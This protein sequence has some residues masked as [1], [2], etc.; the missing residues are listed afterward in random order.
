MKGEKNHNKYASHLSEHTKLLIKERNSLKEEAITTRSNDLWLQ[1]KKAR[2][3]LV[4]IQKKEKKKWAD[5]L[6]G[7]IPNDSKKIWAAAKTI[8]GD[9]KRKQIGEINEKGILLTDPKEVATALNNYFSDKI[10]TIKDEMPKPEI[11]M[12]EVLKAQSPPNIKQQE[13]LEINDTQLRNVVKKIKNTTATGVDTINSIV[14]KDIF[15]SIQ[16]TLLHLVNLSL[17]TGT[18]PEA[19]KM[20][21]ITP[22]VKPNKDAASVSSYR[23]VSNSCIFGKIIEQC[24]IE[25]IRE[26]INSHGLI[27]PNHHGGLKLHSTTTCLL[28]I[29]DAAKDALER[30]RKTALL[31]IDLSSAFDLVNHEMLLQ[32]CR[33]MAMSSNT[34]KWLKSFLS[35]RTHYV[36]VGG[37]KSPPIQMGE[38]GVIQGNISSGDLFV[39]FVNDMPISSIKGIKN[40]KQTEITS[41]MFVDDANSLISAT[42]DNELLVKLKCEFVRMQKYLINHKMKIND[43]KTQLMFLQPSEELRQRTMKI[44]NNVITH[45]KHMK[46]LGLNITDDLK[47]D[48][49]IWSGQQNMIKSLNAKTSILRTL[50]PF[51]SEKV[52]TMVGGNLINS[53]IQYCAPI[54]GTTTASNLA[55]IQGSQIKAARTIV[56]K[57]WNKKE[58][59]AHRQDTLDH[60]K[61]PNTT[62]IVK[63]ATINLTKRALTNNASKGI[64]NMFTSSQSLHTRMCKGLKIKHTGPLSRNETNFTAF[65]VSNF[66]N[67]PSN[68]RDPKMSTTKFK[69]K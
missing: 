68:L 22:I 16:R 63:A 5:K 2:N 7:N 52:L 15:P 59:K 25:Q 46:I 55:K 45:Q 28:E 29:V 47:F 66:N 34:L 20:T 36:E 38:E 57:K 42:S 27:N 44:G 39:I 67:L 64:N 51:V 14:L 37:A 6:L 10:K 31:A 65:A 1:Y 19:F 53:T 50:K 40:N 35:K 30:K 21:K 24:A 13:F 23:P 69:T 9:N 11:D 17:C 62:Q 49:H 58:K 48:S 8:T 41:K 32:K 43:Q 3:S 12:I 54:W 26:H 60:L 33:L 18:Y 61:W 4:L 56:Q